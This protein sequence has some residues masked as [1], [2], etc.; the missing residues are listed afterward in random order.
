MTRNSGQKRAAWFVGLMGA[1]W[2]WTPV[3]AFSGSIF[4]SGHD[5]DFHAFLGGNATGA[6]NII[7]QSLAFA[8]NGNTEPFLLLKSNTS[9]IALGD[10]TDS[11]QGVIASGFTAGN[12]PGAHYVV[13]NATNFATTNLSLFS[14]IFVPSDHGGTLT[15]DDLAALNARSTDIL[16]YLNAGGGLVAFAEDGFRQPASVG[17]QP[18]NFGF[19]PFLVSAAAASQGETGFT[20][21]PFGTSLGLTTADINNNFSHNIFTATGGMNVVDLDAAGRVISLGFRGQIGTG[22]VVPEPAT[23]LLLGSGLM[24]LVYWRSR[25]NRS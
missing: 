11:E 1:L 21:T 3:P 24:G 15:G 20:L 8:R 18:T 10:H 16:N 17:P 14:A 22:G 6:Q 5:P 13:V 9:N 25:K 12:I 19:L 7:T 2:L 4:V 23:L